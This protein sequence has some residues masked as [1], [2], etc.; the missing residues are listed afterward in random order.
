MPSHSAPAPSDEMRAE[1]TLPSA[2]LFDE[3]SNALASARAVLSGLLELVSLEARRAGLAFVWMFACAF[4]AAV[5]V[6]A[7]WL[8]L[9]AALAI[10]AVSLGMPLIAA[11]VAVAVINLAAGAALIYTCIGLSRDLLFRATRRQVA[12]TF[13]AKAS[14]S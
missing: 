3:L 11:V 2:S 12:N 7:A 1:S 4:G 6:V 10:W 5:C 9:A 14:A 8:G 13:P